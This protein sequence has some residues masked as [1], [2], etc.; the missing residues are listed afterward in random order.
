MAS[1]TVT[2]E[3]TREDN[4]DNEIEVSVDVQITIHR[5]NPNSWDSPDDYYGYS[6][7]EVLRST[8]DGCPIDLTE[9]EQNQAET[10]VLEN[11]SFDDLAY[12]GF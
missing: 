12:P 6:E 8:I 4:D 2:T 11:T 1:G 10:W 3:I 5:A 9:D 7:A